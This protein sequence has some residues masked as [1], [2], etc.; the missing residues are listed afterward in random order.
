MVHMDILE[1]H[2]TAQHAAIR[3]FIFFTFHTHLL[4]ASHVPSMEGIK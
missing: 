4:K 2:E 3:T 1:L